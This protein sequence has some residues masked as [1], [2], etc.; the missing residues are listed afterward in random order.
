MIL[1]KDQMS[2]K[3]DKMLGKINNLTDKLIIGL[4]V[5]A[6]IWIFALTFYVVGDVLGRILF[7]NPLPGTPELAKFSIVAITFFQIPYVLMKGRHIR[8]TII[9]DRLPRTLGIYIDTFASVVGLIVFAMIFYGGWD[10]MI[11][12]Y[13]TGAVEGHGALE[14]PTWPA[15]TIIEIGSLLMVVLFVRHIVTN[16]KKIVAKKG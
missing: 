8:T 5:I 14:V 16:I 11:Q 6:T 2:H 3:K 4:N 1:L 9:L 13:H 12:A 15:R 7:R 10:L